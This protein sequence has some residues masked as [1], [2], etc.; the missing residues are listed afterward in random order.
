MEDKYGKKW[1][2]GK[3]TLRG[4]KGNRRGRMEGEKVKKMPDKDVIIGEGGE[5]E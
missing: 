4:D 2:I 5:R 1:K 3:Q